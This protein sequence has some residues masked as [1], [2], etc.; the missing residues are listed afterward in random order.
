MKVTVS[1]DEE[2]GLLNIQTSGGTL[3]LSQTETGALY[4]ILKKALGWRGRF[5]L[6][7]H[8]RVFSEI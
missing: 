5:T 4:I 3:S 2:T 7:R 8:R 1:Y 6:W